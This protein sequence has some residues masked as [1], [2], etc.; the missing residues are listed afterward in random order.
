MSKLKLKYDRLTIRQT[1][2]LLGL[3][4]AQFAEKIGV[5]QTMVSQWEKGRA[6]P[7]PTNQKKVQ[8]LVTK[9]SP[10]AK[11]DFDNWI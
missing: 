3:N 10:D 4:Q 1:R 7:Y 5:S 9:V 2:L 11:I 8:K 6:K